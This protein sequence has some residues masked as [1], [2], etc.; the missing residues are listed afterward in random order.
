[1]VK[2]VLSPPLLVVRPLKNY[3]F[4]CVSSLIIR[5][6]LYNNH[7]QFLKLDTT[8]KNNFYLKI[9]FKSPDKNVNWV[10]LCNYDAVCSF[11]YEED[12]SK[13]KYNWFRTKCA[14]YLCLYYIIKR[15]WKPLKY[16]FRLFEAQKV[17]SLGGGAILLAKHLI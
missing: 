16:V 12:C 8:L 3:F 2:G 1:M 7:G 17:F 4:M 6:F 5:I 11:F 13:L 14:K 9:I 15:H 10:K